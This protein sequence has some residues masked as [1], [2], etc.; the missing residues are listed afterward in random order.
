MSAARRRSSI[1]RR[2]RREPSSPMFTVVALPDTQKYSQS[3]PEVF[4]CQTRW[5]KEHRDEHNIVYVV[6]EGDIVQHSESEV[7]W[8]AANASMS[9]LDGVV[10]Y[11]FSVGNHDMANGGDTDDR[12]TSV[13]VFNSYFPVGRY[14]SEAW[15]GGSMDGG[16]ENCFA[17]FEACGMRFMVI[18]LEMAPRDEVLRWGNEVVSA[19]SDR[20]VIVATHIYMNAGD[21]RVGKDSPWDPRGYR[22]AQAEG[23]DGDDIWRKLVSLHPNIFLV[24]SGHIGESGVGRLTSMGEPGNSVHQLVA[25]YQKQPNGGNGWLRLMRFLPAESRIS[26]STFS[27]YL[28]AFKL[29][30]ANGFELDYPMPSGLT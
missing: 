24:L 16:N 21:A 1:D 27:P 13:N 29:D 30:A 25:N 19:H 20:R 18:S 4:T 8:S 17:F 23:N 9:L 12:E 28:D 15:Y 5:I 14:C 10:P 26:V 2:P 11:T 22:I 6:H 3:F 7:E